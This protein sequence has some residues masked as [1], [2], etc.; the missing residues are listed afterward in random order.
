MH[1]ARPAG[2][3]TGPPK[4]KC[5]YICN[6]KPVLSEHGQSCFEN[7]LPDYFWYFNKYQAQTRLGASS[8]RNVSEGSAITH[9]KWAY[10]NSRVFAIHASLFGVH[11]RDAVC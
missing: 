5:I 3:T 6:Q 10:A 4:D 11:H 2:K 8:L 9:N 1:L 7:Q